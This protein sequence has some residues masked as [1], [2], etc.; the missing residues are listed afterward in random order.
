METGENEEHM[1]PS[2]KFYKEYNKSYVNLDN[3]SKCEDLTGKI[4]G[5][6][7]IDKLCNRLIMNLKNLNNKDKNDPSV[8]YDCTYLHYWMNDSVIK[9]LNE[10]YYDQ[11]IPIITKLIVVWANIKGT[12]NPSKYVCEHPTGPL[13]NLSAKEFKFRKEMYD[14]YYNY[15]KI[16]D[17]DFSNISDCTETCKYLNTI[18]EKYG[19]FRSDCSPSK[20]NKCVPEFKNFDDYDPIHLINKLGCKIPRKCNK[21]KVLAHD[22]TFEG[23]PT[24]EVNIQD[25]TVK[26]NNQGYMENS[27]RT[28]ILN[29]ALPA[30]VFFVLFP[31][32]YKMTPLGSR[33]G[34]ANKIRN[35]II[36]DLKNEE[37]EHFLAHAFEQESMNNSDRT[38]N[39]SYNN[40]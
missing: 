37:G 21:D 40:T 3:N 18:N 38:Y 36:N 22:G 25:E 34:K 31:M 35:N 2:E 26:D 5:F 8:I 19:T 39:I 13:I 16:N 9:E 32:L 24:T 28:T 14:Y 6:P 27:N 11:Y 20:H 15:R 30:S 12:L 33:F 4:P 10:A 17:W 1:L 29:V 23:K 7:D